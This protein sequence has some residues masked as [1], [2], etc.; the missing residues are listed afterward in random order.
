[1]SCHA[2]ARLGLQGSRDNPH[3]PWDMGQWG[4]PHQAMGYR[5]VESFPLSYGTWGS[6]DIPTE[7]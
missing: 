4:C 5:A 7:P 6:R 1:M 2:M 3:R